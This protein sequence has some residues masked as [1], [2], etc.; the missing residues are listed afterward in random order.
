MIKQQ[1]ICLNGSETQIV[2]HGVHQVS[3]LG[4]LP[5]IIYINDLDC[6]S[7][8]CSGAHLGGKGDTFPAL[9]KKMGFEKAICPENS[10]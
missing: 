7:R 8:Y 4:P 3:L 6:A 10:S 1:L 9:K 5:F 2:K